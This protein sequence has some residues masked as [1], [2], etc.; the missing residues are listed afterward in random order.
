MSDYRLPKLC[1]LR[2]KQLM[3]NG[4]IRFNWLLQVKYY[5]TLAEKEDLWD[6]SIN[7]GGNLV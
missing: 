6:S 5:F 2:L 3:S 1:F 7:A 4:D